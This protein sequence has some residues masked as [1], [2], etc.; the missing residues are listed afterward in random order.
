M[1][2][3]VMLGFPPMV[4]AIPPLVIGAPASFSLGIQLPPPVFGLAAA[5]A[6]IMNRLIQPRFRLFNRVLTVRSVV[7]MRRR[8]RRKER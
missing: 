8:R 5:L 3:P 7:G 4:F 6:V 1:I 2:F